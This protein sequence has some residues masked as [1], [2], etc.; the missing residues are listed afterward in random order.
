VSAR[1]TSDGARRP[2][3]ARIAARADDICKL[4]D[5]HPSPARA[6]PEQTAQTTQEPL[7]A[8][9]Q[10]PDA[11]IQLKVRNPTPAACETATH[12]PQ[13]RPS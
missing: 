6:T 7:F 12:A 10:P 5:K 4:G 3:G 1:A 11:M 13:S 2:C 9:L 8:T